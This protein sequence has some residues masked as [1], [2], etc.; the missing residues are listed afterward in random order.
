MQVERD[1]VEGEKGQIEVMAEKVWNE[2]ERD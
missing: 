1:E 2:V